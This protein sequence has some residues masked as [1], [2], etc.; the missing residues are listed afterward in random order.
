MLKIYVLRLEELLPSPIVT[1]WLEILPKEKQELLKKRK[2]IAS[3]ER[4]LAGEVLC[5]YALSLY[6]NVSPKDIVFSYSEHG[7]PFIEG[8]PI[9]F[10]ISHSHNLVVCALSDCPVG[11]DTEMIKDYKEGLAKR[12]CS[13]SEYNFL[14]ESQQDKTD[15]FK[16]WTLKESYVKAIGKG[17]TFPLSRVNFIHSN[18]NIIT[19][20][21]DADFYIVNVGNDN[22]ASVCLLKNKIIGGCK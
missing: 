4:S 13:E 10:N 22:I 14:L 18:N 16:L 11:I 17:L 19:L 2:N 20:K 9:F 5:R 6:L 3:F 12:V 8:N 7:K 15:F 21:E 1:A